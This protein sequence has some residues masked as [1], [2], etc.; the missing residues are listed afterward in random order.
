MRHTIAAKSAELLHRL[1]TETAQRAAA[2]AISKT[3]PRSGLGLFRPFHVLQ[4]KVCQTA[5]LQQ[6]KGSNTVWTWIVPSS[7]YKYVQ[8]E[9][10]ASTLA[11]E[12]GTSTS[13]EQHNFLSAAGGWHL[14]VWHQRGGATAP[15]TH[16]S[17]RKNLRAESNDNW[18]RS[19]TRIT[20]TRMPKRL[21][22]VQIFVALDIPGQLASISFGRTRS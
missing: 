12:L 8:I 13:C 9:I 17:H 6:I 10:A 18:N 22:E 11:A 5:P 20:P 1:L 19:N 16:E 15:A 2:A 14:H 7:C 3:L 21:P 4:L